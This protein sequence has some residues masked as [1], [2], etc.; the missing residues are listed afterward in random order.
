[1]EINVVKVLGA[2]GSKGINKEMTCLQVSQSI[3]IDAGNILHSLEDKALDINHIF[4]THTHLDHIVDIPFLI[5]TFFDKRKEPLIIYGLKDTITHLQDNLFNWHIWPDFSSI[6]LKDSEQKAVVFKEITLN[7]EI[8]VDNCI[9]KPIKTEHAA[10]SCGYVITKDETSIL[11]TSDTYKCQNIWDEVNTNKTIKSIIIEASFPSRFEQLA[12]D[13]KHLTPKLLEEEL[14]CLKRDDVTIY[15]NHLKSAYANEISEECYKLNILLNNGHVLTDGALIDITNPN[16]YKA[17]KLNEINKEKDNINQ[18]IDIGHA[19]TSQKNFD[20][21]MEKILLGAKQLSGAD[22][23]TLYIMTDDEK[24]LHFTVVQTDSLGL[25]MG[26]TNGT[27]AWPNLSLVKEDGTQNREQVAV[28]CAIEGELINIHDVY[29]AEGF[30]FE[31]TK[32]FDAGTGYRTKSMLVVPMKNHE[33]DIIGVIQLLNK[34][35]KYGQTI[36]FNKHDE[37]LILSMSSQAAISVTNTRLIEG[38]ENLLNAFIKTIAVAIG[39]KSKYTGGHINRVAE[40]SSIIANAINDDDSDIYK[41]ISFCENEIKEINISA[42]MHDIGKITTPEFV[43]DKATKL[44]TIYDRIHFVEAKFEIFKRD[45]EIILLKDKLNNKNTVNIQQLEDESLQLIK[46][47]EDDINFIKDVNIGGE[48]LSDDKIDRINTL[49]EYTINIDNQK[50]N[51]LSQ[52]EVNNL[53]IRKGTLTQEERE[54]INNHAAVSYHMLKE[55]PFPKKLKNIPL[56]AGSH[57][58]KVKLDENGVHTGYGAPEIMGIPMDIKSKILAVADIF[59]AL[60]AHDRPYREPNSLNQS[61][62]ILSFMVKDEELDKDLVKFFVDKGLAYTYAK[63]NLLESQLDEITVD[64][65]KL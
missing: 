49:V 32:A 13:S 1:M 56:I 6:N 17:Y 29:K 63:D 34:Q 61:L 38:L 14:H 20:V 46:K 54:V 7:K 27:I 30:N 18:L 59:E 48:F 5:D 55:L 12:F 57:H 31:G 26:G 39:E 60:T 45:I 51:L 64:F 42:W 33:N 10:S 36:D 11:F 15:V 47:I 37:E 53:C 9:L 35:D 41:D 25:K 3:V 58:K 62:K 21:L 40:L 4:L 2:F 16:N 44:E 65:G 43:V 50:I 23:G 24:H 8:T 28:L 19:L 22:G 52:D